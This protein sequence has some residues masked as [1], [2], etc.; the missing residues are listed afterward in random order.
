MKA[1]PGQ[2]RMVWVWGA[3]HHKNVSV[4]SWDHIGDVAHKGDDKD[5]LSW[6]YQKTHAP[7]CPFRPKN[8]KTNFR[9]MFWWFGELWGDAEKSYASVSV[10]F[11]LFGREKSQ[12]KNH[13]NHFLVFNT[14]NSSPIVIVCPRNPKSDFLGKCKK[15]RAGQWS[16]SVLSKVNLEPYDAIWCQF[17]S[18]FSSPK[19][20]N[21]S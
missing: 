5:I 9:N 16:R 20:K 11:E 13:Q 3:P 14:S 8:L 6:R 1:L 18:Q 2:S 4:A 10:K 7:Y 12:E 21:A 17:G 15:T 19:T